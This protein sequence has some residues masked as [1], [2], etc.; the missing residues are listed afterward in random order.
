MSITPIVER[1]SEYAA[2]VI[3]EELKILVTEL[4]HDTD[5]RSLRNLE[6]VKLLRIISRI[7]RHFGCEIDE[8]SIYRAVTLGDLVDAVAATLSTPAGTG[9]SS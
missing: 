4:N 8:D 1:V 9:V 5:L 6:S 7:E 3:A 2:S